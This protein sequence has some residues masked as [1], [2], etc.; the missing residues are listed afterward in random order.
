[1][2]R[3]HRHWSRA[4]ADRDG[5]TVRRR[6]DVSTARSLAGR[7]RGV[8]DRGRVDVGLR[9]PIRRRAGG[10]P[11]WCLLR[12]RAPHR[13]GLRVGHLD[14]VE[15]D[16]AAVGDVNRTAPMLPLRPGLPEKATHDYKRNGTTTLFAAL[17][18]ATGKVTD[19][20]YDRHGKAEFL[21]FLKKVAKAYPRR[22]LHVMQ[23]NYHTHKH[24]EVNEWLARHPRITLHFTPTSGSWLNLVEVFFG[25]ITRQAIRRGSFNSVKELVTAIRR[26][27]NGWNDRCHP[28]TWTKT[29]DEILSH[30]RRQRT[31][32][33]TLATV[34]GRQSVTA[35]HVD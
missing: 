33:A 28:F 32:D 20:C 18:L 17:E 11:A 21:D 13:T 29:A 1:M 8:V 35:G 16:V 10:L 9:Q 4:A 14:R 15:G 6:L 12:H 24:A 25:I 23:D 26:F 27:I 34:P 3:R 19:H 5:H 2:G 22:E 31:S 30:A 7:G